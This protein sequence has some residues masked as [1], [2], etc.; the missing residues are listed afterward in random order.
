MTFL[1][2]LKL[3]KSKRPQVCPNLGFE[4]QLKAYEKN[5]STPSQT[6]MLNPKKKEREQLPD[7]VKYNPLHTTSYNKSFRHEPLNRGSNLIMSK[8][9]KPS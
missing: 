9:L 6:F 5:H 8:S 4:L 7:I 1:H 2:A 3:L